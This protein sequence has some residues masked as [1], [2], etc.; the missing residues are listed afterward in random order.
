MALALAG[1]MAAA[2]ASAAQL[3]VGVLECIVDPGIGF[4]VASSKALKCTFTPSAGAP[5]RYSGRISKLGLDIGVTGRSI[6]VWAVF[7]GQ[8][9]YSPW[10]LAGNYF[11]IS[12][13]ASVALG[14]GAN[15]LVGGSDKSL[16]LQP[17]SVQAQMGLN[18]AAGVAGM[19]LTRR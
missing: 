12:A 4:I 6:I 9:G 11:G 17:I 13:Q 1:S 2:P 10:S 3:R 8:S 18:L 19:T 5:E 14:V 7:A 16:V 15:A